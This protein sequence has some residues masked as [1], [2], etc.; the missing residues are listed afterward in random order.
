MSS[1]T[2][3]FLSTKRPR[4]HRSKSGAE[5]ETY[6]CPD[7]WF[8]DGNIIIRSILSN[9]NASI[10]CKVHKSILASHSN[11]FHDLFDGPQTAFDVASDRYDGV[12]VMDLPD[13]P[14]EVNDFLKA[15]YFPEETHCHLPISSPFFEG[16]WRG[17]P[18]KYEGILRLALKYDCEPLRDQMI[19]V[20]RHAWPQYLIDWDFLQ[21]RTE[22]LE[23]AYL[24]RE[25]FDMSFAHPE[26]ARTL[27]LAMD[28][29]VVDILPVV[30]YDLMRVHEVIAANPWEIFRRADLSVLTAED[31]RRLA[32]GRGNLRGKYLDDITYLQHDIRLDSCKRIPVSGKLFSGKQSPCHASLKK[33]WDTRLGVASG[34]SVRDPIRWL[35]EEISLCD[36]IPQDEVC[37]GCIRAI[38]KYLERV[39]EELWTSLPYFFGLTSLVSDNWGKEPEPKIWY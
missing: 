25:C 19:N 17:F 29:N 14:S 39:R 20:L 30:F 37:V 15:L 32:H 36:D 9:K 5:I 8:D 31:L 2:D 38:K 16:I 11:A 13:S 6:E 34:P 27:R 35:R 7:L 10:A 26:P 1:P 33:W 21:K 12:P 4:I 3:S 22:D 18:F 24:R 28:C 23:V